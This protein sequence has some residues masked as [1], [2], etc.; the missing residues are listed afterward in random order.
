VIAASALS[1]ARLAISALQIEEVNDL[2]AYRCRRLGV[3]CIVHAFDGS[4]VE[5]LRR[6]GVEH[7]VDSKMQGNIRLVTS[8][9]EL[10]IVAP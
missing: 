6:Q 2:L 9:A 5:E 7:L 1:T 10:G 8:L 3:P 4:L